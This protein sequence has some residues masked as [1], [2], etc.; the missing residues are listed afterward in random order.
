MKTYWICKADMCEFE[1]E[2]SE[3]HADSNYCPI[4]KEKLTCTCKH[5]GHAIHNPKSV[6]CMKCRKPLKD[7]YEVHPIVSP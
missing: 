7:E 1:I 6:Y 4:C 3:K 5:C 2:D